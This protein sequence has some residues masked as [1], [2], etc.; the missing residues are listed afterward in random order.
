[1]QFTVILRTVLERIPDF[2]VSEAVPYPDLGGPNGYVSMKASFA[3]APRQKGR[4]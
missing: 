4:S 1:M 3:P 2:M